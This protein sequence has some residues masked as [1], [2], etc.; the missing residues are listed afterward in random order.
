MINGTKV[1]KKE[2]PG[3]NTLLFYYIPS[4]TESLPQPPELGN[5][6]INNGFLFPIPLICTI[7]ANI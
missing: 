7:F 3:K 1:T 4:L 2:E 6:K 5:K